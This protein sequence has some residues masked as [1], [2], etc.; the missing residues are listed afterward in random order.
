[1]CS[2]VLLT[3]YLDDSG[4]SFSAHKECV[5]SVPTTCPGTKTVPLI[6]LRSQCSK[7]L[8][9][10]V[11]ERC[12]SIEAT[13]RGGPWCDNTRWLCETT[14]NHRT[15]SLASASV[16]VSLVSDKLERCLQGRGSRRARKDD[17][18]ISTKRNRVMCKG[19]YDGIFFIVLLLLFLTSLLSTRLQETTLS[20]TLHSTSLPFTVNLS[21]SLCS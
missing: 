19:M 13:I 5:G 10:A 9:C 1:M 15:S 12:R 20:I 17:R 16:K 11:T 18:R 4:C 14:Y 6:T 3:V 7:S 8:I 21:A 2:T